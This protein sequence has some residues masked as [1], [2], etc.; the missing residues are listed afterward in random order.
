GDDESDSGDDST[1]DDESDSGDSSTGDDESDSGD[2]STGDDESDSGDSSTG[3]DESDSGD[4]STGDDESDSGDDS[5]GDDESDSGDSSTGDDESDS[6]DSS[7][8][9]DESDSGDDSTGDDESD[10]G[11]DS[12]GDDNES[13]QVSIQELIKAVLDDNGQSGCEDMHEAVRALLEELDADIESDP[14]AEMIIEPMMGREF[15]VGSGPVSHDVWLSLSSKVRHPLQRAL[16][17]IGRVKVSHDRRGTQIDQSRLVGIQTGSDLNVYRSEARRTAPTTAVS[18][19][20][21]RSD[22]MSWLTPAEEEAGTLTKMQHANTAALALSMAIDKLKGCTC[23]VG[24]YPFYTGGDCLH[25][26]KSFHQKTNHR[27]DMFRVPAGSDTPTAEAISG[28]LM[29]LLNQPQQRKLMF[30]LTDG[31]PNDWMTTQKAIEHCRLM[32][33]AVIGIG[34]QTNRLAGF[35]DCDFVSV[36]DA[37]DLHIAVR[38]ALRQKLFEVAA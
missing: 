33:V 28:A 24:Y 8:G 18:I 31:S 19:V 16:L 25:V 1:G 34:I 2:D 13:S 6:G 36:N 23:E 37:A 12:T 11:D 5:T 26:A 3:D 20:V 7:T 21:D 27:K 22:S 38:E 10:S 4:S 15:N 17:D 29:R 35:E 32:G 9:D 30:V 14:E